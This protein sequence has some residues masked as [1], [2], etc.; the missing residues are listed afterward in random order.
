MI[1]EIAFFLPDGTDKEEF[2]NELNIMCSKTSIIY[3]TQKLTEEKISY[4]VER[5]IN[6]T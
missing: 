5:T 2:I 6:E 1:I 4:F 3:Y